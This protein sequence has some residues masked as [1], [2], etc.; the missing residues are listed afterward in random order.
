M[1]Q[2]KDQATAREQTLRERV[3]E[4][5]LF[6]AQARL[7][8]LP[9]HEPRPDLALS[10]TTNR[11][12]GHELR[13]QGSREPHFAR[14]P[15]C[16]S[17]RAPPA[18]RRLV[19]RLQASVAC[20]SCCTACTTV[21]TRPIPNPNL[22][23]IILPRRSVRIV[24]LPTRSARRGAAHEGKSGECG[25]RKSWPPPKRYT[26][27]R[28]TSSATPQRSSRRYGPRSLLPAARCTRSTQKAASQ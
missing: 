26:R 23:P 6:K 7:E 28:W 2:V 25:R 4:L 3:E 11:T 1:Q 16:S 19:V 24:G 12:E 21:L 15:Q 22:S 27:P 18:S 10:T 17:R 20:S 14:H 13:I 5:S 8:P 9:T